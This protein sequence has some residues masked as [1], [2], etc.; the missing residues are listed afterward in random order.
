VA[1]TGKLCTAKLR[2][3]CAERT[4]EVRLPLQYGPLFRGAS[5]D[6]PKMKTRKSAA[7]RFEITGNGKIVRRSSRQN[8][9]MKQSGSR[10]RRL[11]LG[12]VLDGK[13]AKNVR[14][15]LGSRVVK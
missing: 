8:H 10:K 6:M 2:L 14:L 1:Y 13:F 11:A 15:M 7:K 4:Y 3:C 5:I 9:K 12:D